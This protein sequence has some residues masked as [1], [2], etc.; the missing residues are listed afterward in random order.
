LRNHPIHEKICQY[1]LDFTSPEQSKDLYNRLETNPLPSRFLYESKLAEVK[2]Y[3]KQ[4]KVDNIEQPLNFIFAHASKWLGEI[5]PIFV[6]INRIL[7][8]FF[9]DNAPIA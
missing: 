3:L 6:Q 4:G 8:S 5:H 9:S 1:L 7:A 2:W